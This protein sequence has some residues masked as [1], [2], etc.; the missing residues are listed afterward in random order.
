M[1]VVF[2]ELS[3]G[4][5]LESV[6]E[7][8]DIAVVVE[9][10]EGAV[11]VVGGSDFGNDV[12]FKEGIKMVVDRGS[13]DPRLPGEFADGKFSATFSDE[14]AEEL[15]TGGLSEQ[16]HQRGV[17]AVCAIGVGGCSHTSSQAM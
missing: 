12:E 3:E 17:F 5:A 10:V 2:E 15:C 7:V 11:A 14:D 9:L 13:A 4:D 8:G 1:A 6:A 16:R